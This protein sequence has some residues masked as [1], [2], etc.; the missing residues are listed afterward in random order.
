MQDTALKGVKVL[1]FSSIIAG[2]LCSKTLGDFGAEVIWIENPDKLDVRFYVPFAGGKPGINRSAAYLSVNS[3]KYSMTLDL[4]HP[5]AMEIAKRLI[6]W[7]DVI[8][9][10]FVPGTMEKLG[11]SYTEVRKIKPDIV[12]ISNSGQG[13]TGPFAKQPAFG[14]YIAGLAGL[15]SLTGW[16]DRTEPL[17]PWSPYLDYACGFLMVAIVLGALMHRKKTGQG[18]HIDLSMFEFGCHLVT[19]FILDYLVNKREQSSLGNRLSHAVPHGVYRCFGDDRWCAIAVF[20]DE[21]WESFCNVI[22]H[23][24]WTTDVRFAVLLSRKNNEDELDQLIEEWTV[25]HP[26]EEVMTKMQAAGIAAG[27]VQDAKDIYEDRHLWDRGF[28]Q[29]QPHAEVGEWAWPNSSFRLSRTPCFPKAVPLLGQHTEYIC[30]GILGISDQEFVDLL[31]AGV[32]G[33]R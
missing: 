33:K 22:G 8:T 30:T 24:E 31:K 28:F 20:T 13:Q 12:M 27:V 25:N 14:N 17:A 5:R 32:F 26:P 21:E 18:Q 11:L 3:S 16:P 6:S 19:P 15:N 10:Q 2:P 23:P 9:E 1:D 29:M 7:A 4:Q